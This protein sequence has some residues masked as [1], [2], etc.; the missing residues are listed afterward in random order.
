MKKW[1]D[2][3][4]EGGFL[5][6]STLIVNIGNYGLNLILGRFLGPEEFAAANILTTIV[7]ILSFI[8]LGFQLATAKFVA[9]YKA[10]ELQDKVD[11]FITWIKKSA[12]IFSVSISFILKLY[13][14]KT[15]F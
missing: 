11:S 4:G 13:A 6:I 8:A 10:Q 12:L 9:S 14:M 5:F 7:L 15:Y 3:F 2:R 1:I